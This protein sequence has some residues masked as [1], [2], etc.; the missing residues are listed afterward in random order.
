MR[1]DLSLLGE[2]ERLILD[3]LRERGKAWI[4]GGW[5]RDFLLGISPKELDIATDLKPAVSDN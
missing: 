2:E 4:V 1:V 5:V 3:K